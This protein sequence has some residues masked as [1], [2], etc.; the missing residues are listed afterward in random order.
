[1]TDDTFGCR[2]KKLRVSKGLTQ[3]KLA[4]RM[5]VNPVTVCHWERSKQEPCIEDLKRLCELFG[6]TGSELLGF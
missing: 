2:L 3:T 6:I 5:N 4:E 1:M